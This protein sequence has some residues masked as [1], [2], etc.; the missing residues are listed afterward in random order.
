MNIGKACAIFKQINS[1]E[2]IQ[3]EKLTAIVDVLGMPTHNGIT[4]DEI[5]IA[6]KWLAD[7]TIE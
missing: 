3:E 1:E 5:L 2:Y 6:F 7:L 4:K